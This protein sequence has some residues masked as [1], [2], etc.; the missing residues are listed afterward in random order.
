MA[1]DLREVTNPGEEQPCDRDVDAFAEL[2]ADGH[3]PA[4]IAIMWGKDLDYVGKLL[5]HVR[6][7]L[8]PWSV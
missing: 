4:D 5:A 7:E 3:S 1:T 6:A 8:G 2:L